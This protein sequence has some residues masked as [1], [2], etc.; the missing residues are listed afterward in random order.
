MDSDD[1]MKS[2]SSDGVD[3]PV[4]DIRTLNNED[5]PG[6][7][8]ET[9]QPNPSLQQSEDLP[10]KDVG[11]AQATLPTENAKPLEIPEETTQPTLSFQDIPVVQDIPSIKLTP[12]PQKRQ[13]DLRKVI[14]QNLKL[15]FSIIQSFERQ[16][17]VP[18]LGDLK[19]YFLESGYVR[20]AIDQ[21]RFNSNGIVKYA[22]HFDKV[23]PPKFVEFFETYGETKW[24]I[25]LNTY[26][27]YKRDKSPQ[28]YRVFITNYV[29]LIKT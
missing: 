5:L 23:L 27:K 29:N 4:I 6:K 24:D 17:I 1:D 10:G 19:K 25:L 22:F 15:D 18:K 13:I 21:Y 26:R 3:K 16:Y 8:V 11:I 12:D 28:N 14:D 20:T 7:D 2:V 9:V